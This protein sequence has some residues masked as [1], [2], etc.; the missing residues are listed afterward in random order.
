[1][2]G[3]PLLRCDVRVSRL[4]W[5]EEAI[6]A[7]LGRGMCGT[8]TWGGIPPPVGCDLRQNNLLSVSGIKKACFTVEKGKDGL[9]GTYL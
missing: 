4:S 8:G 6:E 5:R 7:G 3:E 9:G 1:M 2:T